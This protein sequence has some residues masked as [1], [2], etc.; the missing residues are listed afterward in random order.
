[1]GHLGSPIHVPSIRTPT[2][3][4]VVILFTCWLTVIRP[5]TDELHTTVTQK[6]YGGNFDI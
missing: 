4:N 2:N 1:M 6:R 3:D 5:D